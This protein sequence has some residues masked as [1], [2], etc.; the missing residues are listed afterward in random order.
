MDQREQEEIHK[1]TWAEIEIV[2]RYL[3]CNSGIAAQTLNTDT[4][5]RGAAGRDE[6]QRSI[7]ERNAGLQLRALR[8]WSL[9]E[10]IEGPDNR[11][12]RRRRRPESP[13]PLILPPPATNPPPFV[14]TLRACEVAVQAL[15][16]DG[17]EWNYA[18]HMD[19]LSQEEKEASISTYVQTISN[20]SARQRAKEEEALLQ[21]WNQYKLL[22][23]ELEA[24]RTRKRQQQSLFN[25]EILALKE[26]QRKWKMHQKRLRDSM[27][28]V[29]AT[30][31]QF[32]L[33]RRKLGLE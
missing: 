4:N 20:L 32:K 29:N 27:E 2:V 6:R 22:Q 9:D 5:A 18:N 30:E 16:D 15:Q 7:A 25:E 8:S 3:E 24:A 11:N 17:E 19:H 10:D 21:N 12:R 14:G 26:A 31:T 13:P 23:V 33:A 1:Q 28:V